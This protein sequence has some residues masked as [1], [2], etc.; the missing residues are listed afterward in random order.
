M[1]FEFLPPESEQFGWIAE[2]VQVRVS[3]RTPLAGIPVDERVGRARHG[4]VHA[5]SGTRRLREPRFPGA[6]RSG[7]RDEDPLAIRD[8]ADLSPPTYEPRLVQQGGP[9]AGSPAEIGSPGGRVPFPSPI[10]ARI[11][12]SSSRS[13]AAVSKSSAAAAARMSFSIAS[14]SASGDSSS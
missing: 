8:R 10:R 7:E 6:E 9:H 13:R 4:F 14:A 2:P 5:R 1:G 12:N 3:D 11:S